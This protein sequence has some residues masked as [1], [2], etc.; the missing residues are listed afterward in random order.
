MLVDG[1]Q[2]IAHQL[3]LFVH[4]HLF[5]S[6]LL[7]VSPETAW[8]PPICSVQFYLAIQLF[9][10]S[11][12]VRQLFSLFLEFT[13]RSLAAEQFFWL[14]SSSCSWKRQLKAGLQRA[15]AR[16][17]DHHVPLLRIFLTLYTVVHIFTPIPSSFLFLHIHWDNLINQLSSYITIKAVRSIYKDVSPSWFLPS[18]VVG[19]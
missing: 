7:F 5:I 2:K 13:D 14:S 15:D 4:Q 9:S 6:P 19:K 8:K 3:V 1:K 10:C 12:T 16:F 18:S 11:D 17:E